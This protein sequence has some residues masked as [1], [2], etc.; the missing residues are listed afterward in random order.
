MLHQ[1]FAYG[2]NMNLTALRTWIADRMPGEVRLD[3]ARL[4]TLHDYRFRSNYFSI[5]PGAGAANIE[6]VNGNRVEGVFLGIDTELRKLL[7]RKEGWPHIYQE[8]EVR[9]TANGERRPRRAFT[10]MVASD[11]QLPEDLAVSRAYRNTILEAGRQLPLSPS[12]QRMLA[13]VL[14][15]V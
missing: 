4:A 1:Y 6:P 14:V 8:H 12:Y 9:V 3:Q 15:A 11:W 5:P 7:R 2:S 10:F 13:Q